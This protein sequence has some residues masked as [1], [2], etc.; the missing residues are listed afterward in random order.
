MGL[1]PPAVAD[2]GGEAPPGGAQVGGRQERDE[3]EQIKLCAGGGVARGYSRHL[4]GGSAAVPGARDVAP[5]PA[6]R[7]APPGT[8]LGAPAAPALRGSPLGAR[9][10]G[11]EP[12]PP[13]RRPRRCLGGTCSL[14]GAAAPAAGWELAPPE[15]TVVCWQNVAFV[16]LVAGGGVCGKGRSDCNLCAR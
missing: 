4:S 16:G 8:L 2:G 1:A 6:L 14:L 3:K 9:P 12:G 15:E 10:C 5:P 7:C 13:R 11:S